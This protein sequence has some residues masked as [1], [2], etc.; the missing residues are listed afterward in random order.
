M[1]L[2]IVKED[3]VGRFEISQ[4][5]FS[6]LGSFIDDYEEGLLIELLGVELFKLFKLDINNTTKK[7]NTTKYLVLYDPFSADH[8]HGIIISKGMKEMLLGFIYCEYTKKLP[9]KSTIIG[10]VI[11]APEIS[12][13]AEFNYSN[14]YKFYNDAVDTH[15]S[16]RWKIQ[17]TQSVDYP[18]YNGKCKKINYWV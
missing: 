8:Q 17:Q 13:N 2:L 3:F 12:T 16:I 6:I 10:S 9:F 1:G 18:L 4:D 7:P 11:N 5:N 15:E 14:F